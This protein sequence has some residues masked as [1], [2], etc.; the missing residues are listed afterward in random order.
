MIF[1][2]Y[3]ANGG[4]F[5]KQVLTLCTVLSIL[6]PL[7]SR[8]V[9][10][11]TPEATEDVLRQ[12]TLVFTGTVQETSATTMPA[13]KANNSTAVVRV[14]QVIDGSNAPPDLVGK[15]ITVQL[16]EPG[17]V[18]AGMQA[19]FLTKG[20]LLGNSMAVI[21]LGRLPSTTSVQ[22]LSAQ[23]ESTRQ[24]VA[25]GNLQNELATTEA[26]IIG[27]VTGVR[28]SQIPH[29]KSEHDPDWYEA[30]I[31]VENIVKGQL[32]GREIT[33]LFPHSDDVMWHDSPKFTEGERG[34]WLLH[35][36]QARLPGIENQFTSLKALDFQPL[37]EL[38]RVRRLVKAAQ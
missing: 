18:K 27:T 1:S 6:Q 12:A 36:N 24:K 11:Q 29:L 17:S 8:W 20:W 4:I 31:L 19:I 21:E 5:A 3:R 13:V 15:Q 34:I 26:V 7:Q 33:L 28:P 35:R 2:L 38:D 14:D 32:S 30:Q 25:D 23:L 10:A 16:R 22:D 9:R 37:D